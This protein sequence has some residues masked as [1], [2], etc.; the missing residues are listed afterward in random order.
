MGLAEDH[1]R[2]IVK[3]KKRIKNKAIIQYIILAIGTVIALYMV[4]Q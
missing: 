3:Q 4:T 2:N 1:M